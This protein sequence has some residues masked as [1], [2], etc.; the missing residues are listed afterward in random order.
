MLSEVEEVSD[1]V[2]ILNKGQLLHVGTVA[3]I[4][5]HQL[6][7]DIHLLTSPSADVLSQLRSIC[8]STDQEQL[9][10]RVTV[11]DRA[12]FQKVLDILRRAGA[13]IE[14]FSPRK[15]KLEDY[16]LRVITTGVE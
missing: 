13:E 6:E 15:S 4:T 2:A 11:N 14:S 7:Y 9:V 8:K 16:F 1:R 5:S 10:L 12:D 3:D